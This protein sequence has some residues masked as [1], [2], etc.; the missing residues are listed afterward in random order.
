L[1]QLSEPVMSN[2][3]KQNKQRLSVELP[4]EIHQR[5]ISRARQDGRPLV[6]VAAA[7]LEEAL[8]Q[9]EGWEGT[10][11]AAVPTPAADSPAAT[12]H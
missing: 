2:S 6:D 1:Q 8:R 10:G 9:L 7:M 4:L 11:G 12:D 3:A 5:L